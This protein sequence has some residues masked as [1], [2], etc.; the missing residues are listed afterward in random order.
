MSTTLTTT[1]T[2]TTVLN[3]SSVG[4]LT[5]TG[6]DTSSTS[7][8]SFGKLEIREYPMVMGDNPSTSEGPS[9]EIGWEY[10]ACDVLYVEE[11]EGLRP[12]R[13]GMGQLRMP[14][15]F[16]TELLISNGY[17]KNEI[18]QQVARRREMAA[19]RRI[20]ESGRARQLVARVFGR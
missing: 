13:R 8:V 17:S 14:G 5:T 16:R 15:T 4:S 20:G 11:Y 12:H 7:R 10:V 19:Q 9:L 1:T 6:S 3:D 2:T 18:R